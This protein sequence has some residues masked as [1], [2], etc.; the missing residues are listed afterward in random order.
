VDI[1]AWLR[2]LGLEQYEPAFRANEIDEKVLSHL[3]SEDLREIGVVPIGHR[4]RLLDAIAAL[5]TEAPV[6]PETSKD[7]LVGNGDYVRK[8]PKATKR[9]LRAILKGADLCASEP[10]RVAQ[11]LVDRGFTDRYDYSLDALSSIPYGAWREYDP[12]DTVRYYALRLYEAG[13]IKSSP[14]KIIADNTELR[15][16]NELKRELK[17]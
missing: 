11:R 8:Y 9:V 7:C 4:R 2:G 17:A 16:L 6:V 3:T 14:D 1:A 12:E 10:A 15:F 13:L 5:G